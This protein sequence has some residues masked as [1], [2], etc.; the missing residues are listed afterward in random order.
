[1]KI[2]I[3]M[4]IRTWMLKEYIIGKFHLFLV[5]NYSLCY[6]W[7]EPVDQ[8]DKKH[9]ITKINTGA[10]L[11]VWCNMNDIAELFGIEFFSIHQIYNIMFNINTTQI[12]NCH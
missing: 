7:L 5:K 8:F 4:T 2:M 11:W 12:L 10:S 6:H 3:R 9:N 1:M